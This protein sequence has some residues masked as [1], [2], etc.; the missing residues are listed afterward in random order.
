M[1]YL[2]QVLPYG[3][4][5]SYR[6]GHEAVKKLTSQVSKLARDIITKSCGNA[7]CLG[8]CVTSDCTQRS[9]CCS[10]SLL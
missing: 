9:R 8:P 4:A 6:Q 10:S 5:S 7:A 1:A 2:P 3:Y